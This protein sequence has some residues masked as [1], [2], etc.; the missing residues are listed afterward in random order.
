[1]RRWHKLAFA[2]M[3]WT[4]AIGAAAVATA[5][6]KPEGEMR[7][8]AYVTV[9]P[10]WLDPAEAAPGFTSPFW[11]LY[12]LHD[13]LVKPMPGQRMAPSLAESWT[14]S[15]DKLSYEFKLRKGVKFHNGDPFTADDVVFS[16]GRAKG[17]ELHQNVPSDGIY[18]YG[19]WPDVDELYKKQLT[20]TDPE[21]RE[22]ML[23]EIQKILHERTRFAPIWDYFWPSGIGPRV[24]DAALMKVDPYPWSA[25]LEDVKLKKP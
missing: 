1:M 23:H 15:S 16:F 3:A 25:P 10:A 18:A 6:T 19:G 11:V 22:A 21:N 13:A 8:A 12:A 14:E 20:E 24:E 9:P 17:V 4:A 2:V 7:F 5:Q